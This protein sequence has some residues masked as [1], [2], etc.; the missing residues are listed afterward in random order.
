MHTLKEAL[1]GIPIGRFAN[2]ASNLFA[3]DD[4]KARLCDISC[5][6]RNRF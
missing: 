1:Y 3:I 4:L 5:I 6:A 2:I